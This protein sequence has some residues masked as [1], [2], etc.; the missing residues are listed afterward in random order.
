VVGCSTAVLPTLASC[1]ARCPAVKLLVSCALL[2]GWVLVVV[3]REGR[4]KQMLSCADLGAHHLQQQAR[5]TTN[6]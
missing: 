4:L 5:P 2:G 6:F 3:G 1:L